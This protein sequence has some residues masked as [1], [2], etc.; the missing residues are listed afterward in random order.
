[1]F[2][3]DLQVSGKRE[4]PLPLWLAQLLLLAAYGGFGFLAFKKDEETQRAV[5]VA[6][7]LVQKGVETVQ[8]G[9]SRA[10]QLLPSGSK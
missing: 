9:V 6:I 7:G 8:K 5:A 2:T 3:C 1:M 10:Q 4:G